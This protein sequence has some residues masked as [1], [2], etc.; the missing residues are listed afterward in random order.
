MI[1]DSRDGFIDLKAL[2][3]KNEL[4]REDINKLISFMKPLMINATDR[5]VIN[6]DNYIFYFN[7]LLKLN[8]IKTQNDVLTQEMVTGKSIKFINYRWNEK[9]RF[10]FN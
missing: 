7:R 5:N 3:S 8:N 2:I 10:I 1:Y 4:E 6:H 9:L